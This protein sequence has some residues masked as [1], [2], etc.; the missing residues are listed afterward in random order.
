[1]RI[2]T[3]IMVL[4][5]TM[6]V[7]SLL[8]ADELPMDDSVIEGRLANGF[9]YS[10]VVNAKPK[11]RAE[12]RL[13]INI[14]SLEEADDQRGIAHFTEHMAFNGTEHFEK[15]EL[16][17]YLESTGVQFG[18]HLNASTGY[19]RTLYKLSI[20]LRSDNLE[21][22]FTIL[23]DWADGLSF[24]AEEFDKER[25][26]VLAEARSRDDVRRRLFLQFRSLFFADSRFLDREPIGVLET[27]RHIGVDR[28]KEFYD[29]WYRPEFMH[30]VA[31][32]DFD[33]A[34]VE[35]LIQKLFSTLANHHHDKRASRHIPDNN[36][37]RV[38]TLTDSEVT[39]NTLQIHYFDQLDSMRTTQNKRDGLKEAI[40]YRLF[41]MK[42][43]EQLLKEHPAAMSM[44]LSSSRISSHKS[45][46]GFNA[47]YKEGDEREALRELY[48]LIWG[49]EK[50][51]FDESD[52]AIVKK[53]LLSSNEKSYKRVSD[54]RS[55]NIA[56]TLVANKI[57]N[58]IYIDYDYDYNI[59]KRLIDEIT[60]EEVNALYRD[61]L[62]IKDRGI[63]YI[64]TTGKAVSKEE[65]LKI[66]DKARVG[67]ANPSKIEK[68]PTRLLDENLSTKS[69]LSKVFDDTTGV[70][71]YRLENNITV[72]FKY[73]DFTKD[74][75]L[76]KGFSYGGYST[77]ETSML[78]NAKKSSS[79]VGKSAP[80]LF[81]SIVLNKMLSGKRVRA[82]TYVSR[83]SEG[84]SG[85]ASSEDIA[86]MMELIYIKLTKPKIDPIVIANIKKAM[87]SR[88]KQSGRNPKYNFGKEL[89]GYHYS[90][91]PRIQYDTT[92]SI[93]ELNSSMMLDIY[94]D[95]FSDMNNF[96]F[97]IVGDITTD[98]V[99]SMIS[100]YLA[101][102]P[103]SDRVESFV[104]RGYESLKGHRRFVRYLSSDDIANISMVYKSKLP[105]NTKTRLTLNAMK[106]ILGVRLRESIREDKSGVYGINVSA[107]I[108][109]ELN[110]K[111]TCSI[112]FGSD[113]KRRTELISA[114]K[115]SIEKLKADGVTPDEIAT[116]RQK[117]SVE[118]EKSIK[119][120]A[121]WLS[122]MTDSYKY[123]TKIADIYKLPEISKSITSKDIVKIAH[124]VLGQNLLEAELLPIKS[125]KRR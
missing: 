88:V 112:S 125:K 85:S 11:G 51:G 2:K 1:M 70:Y 97:A 19:E 67:V 55:P 48:E 99:E 90:N 26:V 109:R 28:A 75:V 95:R 39:S 54:K 118:Y 31:V 71:H 105:Y 66:I 123:D 113:P 23:Q 52:L 91:H 50:Y 3:M 98:T 13:L 86:S 108:D 27:I 61:I 65:T 117:F 40:I 58:S 94:R 33:T 106:S 37:T 41:N 72:S 77:V 80:A 84:V 57:S 29:T 22:S 32:G 96:H 24:D 63:L 78:D 8:C 34:K 38:M 60:L 93:D 53:Q 92:Q 7:S 110:G 14:G 68:L 16:I 83:L 21:Q 44:S 18:S 5:A 35:G 121:Y 47:V 4:I 107:D 100:R 20:P 114:V 119:S 104:D 10:I 15:N 59:T 46:Y 42:A 49:F 76:L 81:D 17:S 6:V 25:G 115:Q 89:A 101:N 79:W 102:L 69:I 36:L 64:N 73:T 124:I 30:L 103:T 43:S 74:M 120:N 56:N 45:S 87:K 62:T 122:M 116:Y 82:S 111:T 9:G 12:L